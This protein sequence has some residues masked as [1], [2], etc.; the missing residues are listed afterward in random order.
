MLNHLCVWLKKKSYLVIL[1]L[2]FF[3]IIDWDIFVRQYI[4]KKYLF[5]YSR[6]VVAFVDYLWVF[7]S[8]NQIHGQSKICR[9][10]KFVIWYVTLSQTITLFIIIYKLFSVTI[11]FTA[12]VRIPTPNLGDISL[13]NNK[14]PGAVYPF[15]LFLLFLNW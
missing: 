3:M 11:Q 2:F 12:R 13:L 14:I 15:F 1:F 10:K 9:F 5:I 6:A 4:D 7:L 8:P